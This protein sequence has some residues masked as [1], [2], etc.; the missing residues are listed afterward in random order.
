[1]YDEFLKNRYDKENPMKKKVI[2]ILSICAMI[3]TGCGSEGAGA[4]PATETEKGETA[5][6]TEKESE[7]TPADTSVEE[8][9]AKRLCGKYSYN[10]PGD[11]GENE[12]LTIDMVTFG[13]NLYAFC[14]Y[15]LSESGEVMDPYSYFACEFLPNDAADLKN[16]DT[17]SVEVTALCFSNM[18]N[19]GKYWDSGV[20][21][22]IELTE[23]GLVFTNFDNDGFFV[24]EHDASRLFLKDDRVEDGFAYL[25]RN[26][27]NAPD[28]LQGVWMMIG[29]DAPIYLMFE[30]NNLFVYQKSLSKEVYYAAGGCD[31]RDG[32][33]TARANSLGN[34]DMPLEWNGKYELKGSMLSFRMEGDVFPEELS[35]DVLL[36]RVDESEIPVIT[37]DEVNFDE[38]SF[39]SY[40]EDWNMAMSGDED[41]FYGVWTAAETDYDKAVEKAKALSDLGYESYVC[42]SPEWK[43][44]S[45]DAYCCVTAGRYSTEEEAN[46][47]LSNVKN[48]GYPDAYVKH[49]GSRLYTTVD[50]YNYGDVEPEITDERV[51][52]N[53]V[54]VS[55]PYTWYPGFDE[56]SNQYEM[57]L[58]IDQD[59][60]F[61]ESCSKESFGNYREGDT[62][63][64]W[65]QYNY[66]LMGTDPD[67]YVAEGPALSGVFEVGINGAHIDRFFGSYWWD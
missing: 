26:D 15:V 13:D 38:D 16:T 19:A 62:P 23:D 30:G 41:G 28:E 57:T 61:D 53:G 49:T 21:G 25:S 22:T 14:G 24:P 6:Q 56:V 1:M 46:D 52:L 10:L 58:V 20:A 4:T 64:T 67:T 66:D 35:G 40:G 48:D 2:A 27:K 50:Y 43:D 34:G 39:L 37:I 18:S 63:L 31:F 59:T 36:S 32:S 45:S 33:F 7:V 5:P 51:T 11:S 3:L 47:A 12:Y 44:L 17:D 54:K 65:F 42:Y 60:V 8:S 29:K 55:F 9:L